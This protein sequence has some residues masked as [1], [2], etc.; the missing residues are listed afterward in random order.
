MSQKFCEKKKKTKNKQKTKTKKQKTK[1]KKKNKTKQKQKQKNKTKQ[2]K[3]KQRIFAVFK[4]IS[5]ESDLW[6]TLG[7]FTVKKNGKGNLYVTE[8]RSGRNEI[9]RVED[10]H[11]YMCHIYAKEFLDSNFNVAVLDKI[12]IFHEIDHN[13]PNSQKS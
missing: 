11:S 10:N 4:S 13:F 6:V 2:T 1:N 12:S 9:R 7:D 5:W 3:K 8:N